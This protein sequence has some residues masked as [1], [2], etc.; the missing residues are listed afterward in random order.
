[1]PIDLAQIPIAAALFAPD[2]VIVEVNLAAEKLLGVPAGMVLGKSVFALAPSIVPLWQGNVEH[3]RTHGSVTG[4]VEVMTAGGP[5]IVQFVSSLLV[6]DGVELVQTYALDVTAHKTAQELEERLATKHREESLGLVAGGIAHDFNNLLVG[7]LAEAS[8]IADDDA[9]TNEVRDALRR[10]ETA[11]KRMAQ[12][13]RQLLAYSGRGRV[14]IALLDPDAQ[15]R[16]L[17][18]PIG[19]AVR[20]DVVVAI[21]PGAGPVAIE[22][23][24]ALLRQIVLSLVSNGSDAVGT[25]GHV[26]VGSRVVSVDGAPWWQLEVADDGI[27]L[28]PLTL[29][30]IFD[31]F[32]TTKVDRHGL[33]LSAVHGIVR[34][35]RGHID[36]DSAAG[37][38]ARFHVRLP[39]VP[40]AQPPT[41]PRRTPAITSPLAGIQVL[42]ADDEPSVRTTVR[43]LFE[44]RGAIVSVAADGSEAEALLRSKTFGFVLLDVEMPGRRGYELVPIV[45]ETQPSAPVLLMSGF[46]DTRGDVEPDGFLEKPFTSRALDAMIDELLAKP[47][48]RP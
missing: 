31:P 9:L 12:L 27:G 17:A 2:G 32:F 30:R 16:E 28:D 42:I 47:L 38:G 39:I 35:L 41:I 45:R 3:A 20:D 1:M 26:T 34:R 19:R 29:A 5:L 14:V 33:G 10:I 21:E 37:R 18:E 43:R 23:D 11:A 13:T 40:G 46:T 44:R 4:E 48:A 22:A 6:R 8:A 24:P 25:G 36:V 15:L 7:V